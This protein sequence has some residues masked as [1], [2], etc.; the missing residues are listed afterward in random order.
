MKIVDRGG[1]TP[2]VVVPGIQ[3]RWEWMKPAIDALAQRCR[4]ITFSLADEPSCDGPFDETRGFWSYVE[5]VRAALDVAGIP[6]AA[7]CGVSYG[8]LIAAAFAARYPER[9]SSLV[10]VS[11]LPPSWRPDR[12]VRFYLRA[13]RLFTPIFLLASLRL[14]RE[15]AAANGGAVRGAG[16]GLRHAGR[17]LTHMFSP[18]RMARRVALVASVDLPAIFA[19]VTQPTLVITGEPSLDRVVPVSSITR[20]YAALWANV[21]FATLERTGHLGLITRPKELARLVV[22][23]ADA[24][25]HGDVLRSRVG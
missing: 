23:F 20:E 10:L 3:G 5:Q 4:V 8:G 9:A 16:A 21:H 1:G 25:A 7:I 12:R 6:R 24:A 2:V 11:A 19:R 15:I 18:H 13:P 14:Y 17:V 22:S